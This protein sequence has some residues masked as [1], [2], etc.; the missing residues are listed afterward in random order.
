MIKFV[1]IN[2]HLY[3]LFHMIDSIV[4][5]Y[6]PNTPYQICFPLLTKH[7]YFLMA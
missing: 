7:I 4:E 1:D 6:I 3:F 5:Q 2:L